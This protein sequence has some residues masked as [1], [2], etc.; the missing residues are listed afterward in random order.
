MQ[1][2]CVMT[3]NLEQDYKRWPVRR[4]LILDENRAAKA[5][6]DGAQRVAYL[7][8]LAVISAGQLGY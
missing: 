2:L 8:R 7:Y 3:L 6:F 5:R 1:F 4:P